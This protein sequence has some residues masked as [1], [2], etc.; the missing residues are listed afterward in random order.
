MTLN[1]QGVV[2]HQCGKP[3]KRGEAGLKAHL[4]GVGKKCELARIPNWKGFNYFCPFGCLMFTR[5]LEIAQHLVKAHSEKELKPWY[6]SSENLLR[7][8]AAEKEHLS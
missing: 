3:M 7:F 5:P 4:E 8:I 6:L 1:Y 2:C